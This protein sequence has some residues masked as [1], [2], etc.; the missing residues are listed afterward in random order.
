MDRILSESQYKH[1]KGYLFVCP[2]D[3]IKVG[4][5]ILDSRYT[6]SMQVISKGAD[7]DLDGIYPNIK[8]IHPKR[9]NG[10]SFDP[11]N[12]ISAKGNLEER[13]IKISIEQARDWYK[14]N[15]PILKELALSAYRKEEMK[16]DWAYISSHTPS[17]IICTKV[18]LEDRS[19]VVNSK[20]A[21][22]AKYFNGDWKM[23]TG[24]PG[25]FI[26][27]RVNRGFHG[28]IVINAKKGIEVLEHTIVQ[29]AGVVY[30]KNAEDA[31]K[32]ALLLGDELDYIF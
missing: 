19:I 26:G 23:E 11:N 21:L 30:F 16:E 12:P 14:S 20:L 5:V 7:F 29:Y 6:S 31:K 17:T 10:K 2:Y 22:I 18:P 13:C 4:D 3:S 15:D 32:A 1:L 28:R 9:V 25:Y 8:C 27:K 24:K